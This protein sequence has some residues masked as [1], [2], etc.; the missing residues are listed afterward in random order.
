MIELIDS[1]PANYVPCGSCPAHVDNTC[2]GDGDCE[3]AVEN[4]REKIL[5]F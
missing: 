2:V 5:I 1:Q 3:G 4:E